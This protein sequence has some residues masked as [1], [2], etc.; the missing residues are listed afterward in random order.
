MQNTPFDMSGETVL[1]TGGGTGLGKQFAIAL[2]KAN[3]RV[4]LCARRLEKLEESVAL[5]REQGGEAH[6]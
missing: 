3:A 2:A 1:I 4:I 5:I 6:A